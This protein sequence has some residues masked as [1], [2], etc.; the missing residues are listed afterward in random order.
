VRALGRRFLV[1]GGDHA[2]LRVGDVVLDQRLRVARRG[3][4]VLDLT[5]TEWNLLECLLR[6][7]GQALTR[8]QILDYV[9]SYE[10][11]VLPTMVDVYISYLRRKLEMPGRPDPIQTVRGVGYRWRDGDV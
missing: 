2:E 5:A 11:D 4:H 7:P 6:H 10:A 1:V 3:E 8:P 9:W